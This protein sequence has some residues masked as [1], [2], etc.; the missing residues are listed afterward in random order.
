MV[1]GKGGREQRLDGYDRRRNILFIIVSR[2]F[3]LFI[4]NF[5]KRLA[6]SGIL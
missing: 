2:T 6:L 5:I 4:S 3:F 1:C